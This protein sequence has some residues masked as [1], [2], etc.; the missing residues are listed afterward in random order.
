[1]QEE[2]LKQTV[3]RAQQ[4]RLPESVRRIISELEAHRFEAYAVGGCVRDSMLGRVPEDWDI[5]TSARPEEVKR[6]FRRTVDTGIAHGTVTVMLREGQGQNL[7][8]YE[9][10]TYRIDGDYLDGRHP[11]SVAFTPSLSEDL[12]RRDF[13]INAMAYN[14]RAGLVDLFHGVEDLNAKLLRCVGTARE[15]FEE[16]ALRIL[17]AVRFAAQLDFQLE[18]E[19]EAAMQAQAANLRHVSRERILTEL[20]KLVCAAYPQRGEAL[21]RLGMAPYL[22]EGF[23]ALSA[24]PLRLLHRQTG[25]EG[26]KALSEMAEECS[27][28][29][30]LLPRTEA[31]TPQVYQAAFDLSQETSQSFRYLRFAFLMLGSSGKAAER[32]LRALRADNET[33]RK[34]KCLTDWLLRPIPAERF[35]LKRVMQQMEPQLFCDLL[36]AKHTCAELPLYRERCPEEDSKALLHLLREILRNGEPVYLRQLAVT[37]ADLMQAGMPAGPA[38]GKCLAALLE[39]VQ[40]EPEHNTPE[41]LLAAVRAQMENCGGVNGLENKPT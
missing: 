20:S 15:R 35:A 37:G 4:I 2:R 30:H 19:T 23:D 40:R 38:L 17:R 39:D 14:E 33:I 24:E 25:A 28:L 10:T 13:T 32:L 6:I 1:M 8:G 34:T 29:L 9:V 27:A 3:C 16:D 22:C 5:T 36:L 21:F 12:R 41:F 26:T 31:K 11:S 18:A 7:K